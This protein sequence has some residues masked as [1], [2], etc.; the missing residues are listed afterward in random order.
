MIGYV[1]KGVVKAGMFWMGI[2][3]KLKDA[4]T[5]PT[6]SRRYQPKEE[7]QGA[8]ERLRKEVD[9]KSKVQGGVEVP[10]GTHAG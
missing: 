10:K 8:L 3:R 9:G 5:K 7:E 4:A 6:D 2:T 1:V